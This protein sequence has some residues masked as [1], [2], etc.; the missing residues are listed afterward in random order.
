MEIIKNLVKRKRDILIHSLQYMPRSQR[1]VVKKAYL[2]AEDAHKFQKRLSGEPYIVHPLNVALIL[3]GYQLDYE[4]ICA[5]LLHDVLEDTTIGENYIAS[6]FGDAV[7]RLVKAVTKISVIKKQSRLSKEGENIRRV[8]MATID[9][10]RVILVKLADKLHNLRTLQYQPGKKAVRIA[11]EALDIYAQLAGR[12]GIYRM[13]SEMEDLCMVF[14]YP[15]K[16]KEIKENVS[17]KKHIRNHTVKVINHLLSQ[18][19]KEEKIKCRVE[20]RSKHFYSIYM[21]MTDKN[22]TFDE[23]YDL[24]G[25][26]VIVS[27]TGDCYKALGVIHQLWRPL[28]ERFKDY[29][30]SP[31]PNGYQSIHTTVLGADGKPIEFQIRTEAMHIASQVGI[32]AHWA[33]KSNQP[34]SS[35]DYLERVKN[36]NLFDQRL[37]SG[38]FLKELK[39]TLNEEEIYVYTPKGEIVTLPH[40]ATVLDFAFRIHT[41]LGIHCAGAEVDGRIVSLRTILKN[42]SRVRIL[43]NGAVLP[44]RSWLNYLHSSQVR[45]KLRGY[46]KKHPSARGRKGEV[47]GSPAEGGRFIPREF[48]LATGLEPANCRYNLSSCCL[49][50]PTREIVGRVT[51]KCIELH[52]SD[53]EKISK[54]KKED[55]SEIKW[56]QFAGPLEAEVHLSVDHN[57]QGMAELF[58]ILHLS[59]VRLVR[60]RSEAL[61]IEKL[62]S[63]IY[64]EFDSVLHLNNVL[65][66][67]SRNVGMT[68]VK[69]LQF[70]YEKAY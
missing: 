41:E 26:R 70:W 9:D 6:E 24:I 65:D 20:G 44:N 35:I 62:G 48:I 60:M 10:P 66:T 54:L 46:L 27:K 43:T 28:P 61:D 67:L 12:F 23:I 38:E 68:G 13:K 57:T 2:L 14:L 40:G 49:P 31:K 51:S 30:A 33:Y 19:M 56:N 22:H 25:S 53:C 7:V 29:I 1:T 36:L 50:D 3:A 18:R 4:T 37:T 5:G 69:V 63:T 58:N 8:I 59:G 52:N 15:D 11:R 47:G 55:L 42:G 16:Y 17:Q 64:I 39:A 34:V 21:K 45:N 32:A